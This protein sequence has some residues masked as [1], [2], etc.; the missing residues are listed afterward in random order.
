MKKATLASTVVWLVAALLMIGWQIARQS[1]TVMSDGVFSHAMTW[2]C[3]GVL[4]ASIGLMKSVDRR[5]LFPSPLNTRTRNAL[6]VSNFIAGVVAALGFAYLAGAFGSVDP[7]SI[8]FAAAVAALLAGTAFQA[9]F[10]IVTR[11]GMSD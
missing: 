1:G 7:H 11:R 5:E 10:A 6:N 3:I 9:T 8:L 2:L 4:A